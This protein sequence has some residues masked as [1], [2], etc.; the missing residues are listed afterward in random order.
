M[1]VRGVKS[2][3]EGEREEEEGE[4]VVLAVGNAGMKAEYFVVDLFV[5][6]AASAG[7]L[8]PRECVWLSS[9]RFAA[10]STLCI[11]SD[12]IAYPYHA[13]IAACSIHSPAFVRIACR[14]ANLV[15]QCAMR[16]DSIR[17]GISAAT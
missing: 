10:S 5:D 6:E 14:G 3:G 12:V 2:V 9:V 13:R 16:F 4:R 8:Q 7:L 15:V 17:E 1:R 11:R